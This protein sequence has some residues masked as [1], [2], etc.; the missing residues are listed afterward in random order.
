MTVAWSDIQPDRE[1]AIFTL[2]QEAEREGR[3]PSLTPHRTIR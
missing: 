1:K 2:L 3:R